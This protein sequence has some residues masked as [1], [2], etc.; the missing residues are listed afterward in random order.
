MVYVSCFICSKTR[1]KTPQQLRNTKHN[2]CSREC[3]H[4]YREFIKHNELNTY[5]QNKLKFYAEVRRSRNENK[6]KGIF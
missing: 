1:N 2:F 5:Y 6:T 3:Y 4:I